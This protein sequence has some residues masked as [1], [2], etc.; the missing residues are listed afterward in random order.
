MDKG[1]YSNL[2]FGF[3]W[4]PGPSYPLDELLKALEENKKL[5]ERM[6][7]EKDAIIEKLLNEKK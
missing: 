4:C 7:K 6:L 1:F 3:I 5:Y 2:S